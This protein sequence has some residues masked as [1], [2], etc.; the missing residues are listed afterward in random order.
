[1][2]TPMALQ[3]AEHI[4]QQT[5]LEEDVSGPKLIAGKPLTLPLSHFWKVGEQ[6]RQWQTQGAVKFEEKKKNVR[7]RQGLNRN[8][9][10][11]KHGKY[12]KKGRKKIKK[13]PQSGRT[14][15]QTGYTDN[16]QSNW[17]S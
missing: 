8:Q 12:R 14:E 3:Q 11:G 4:R 17:R 2:A 10:N 5:V 16:W 15:A 6:E 1:M 9:N 7:Q 13:R